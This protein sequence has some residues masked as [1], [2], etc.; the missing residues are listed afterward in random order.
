ML[1][2]S[3]DRERLCLTIGE[4][5]SQSRFFWQVI[6]L[7]RR[8]SPRNENFSGLMVTTSSEVTMGGH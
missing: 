8:H 1:R 5:T 6:G 4:P 2:R 3:I 7:K